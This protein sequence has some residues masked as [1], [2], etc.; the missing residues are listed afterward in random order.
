MAEFTPPRNK[1]DAPF[2]WFDTAPLYGHDDGAVIIELA[3]RTIVASTTG[4]ATSEFVIAGRLRCTATGA[5]DLRSAIDSA[6]K[7]IEKSELSNPP[8]ARRESTD[9]KTKA[10]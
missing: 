4:G 3:A 10:N 7:M 6:L 5:K 1:D 2:V 8:T 9:A